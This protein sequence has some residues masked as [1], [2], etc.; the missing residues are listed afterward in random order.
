MI[1]TEQNLHG[2]RHAFTI[3]NLYGTGPGF[4]R[5][6]LPG[7]GIPAALSRKGRP[8]GSGGDERAL[9]E[10]ENIREAMARPCCY[11]HLLFAQDSGNP[12]AKSSPRRSMETEN[13]V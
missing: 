2:T 4:R 9:A 12:D 10:L 6:S 11:A 13:S 5:Q 8:D 7:K 1:M 3:G